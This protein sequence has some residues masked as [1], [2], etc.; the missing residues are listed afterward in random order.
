MHC[1]YTVTSKFLDKI[2]SGYAYLILCRDGDQEFS[3]H[4]PRVAPEHLEGSFRC[5]A[6]NELGGDGLDIALAASPEVVDFDDENWTF[7]KDT[8]ALRTTAESGSKSPS[9]A[10]VTYQRISTGAVLA[11]LAVVCISIL[12]AERL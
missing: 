10:A 6:R 11:N 4:I 2:S 5:E 1:R 3:L 7:V 8:G 12:A 9:S